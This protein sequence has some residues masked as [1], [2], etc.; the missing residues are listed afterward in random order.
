MVFN[1]S[2]DHAIDEKGRVSI[3]VRFREALER[4]H[5]ETLVITNNFTGTK[6]CLQVYPPDE[7]QRRVVARVQQKPHFDP[8]IEDYLNFIVSRAHEVPLDRQGRILIPPNLREFAGLDRDVTFTARLT[9]FQLWDKATFAEVF[10][11]S[12]EKFKDPD[13]RRKLAL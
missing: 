3:P 10:A 2:F 9:Y 1:G 7:W 11:A 6:P 5:C 12:A 4:D 13:F 8:D